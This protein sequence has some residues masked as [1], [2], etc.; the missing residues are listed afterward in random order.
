MATHPSLHPRAVGVQRLRRRV[1]GT[2]AVLTLAVLATACGSSPAPGDPGPR[3]TRAGDCNDMPHLHADPGFVLGFD[4]HRGEHRYDETVVVYA[5]ASDS[6]PSTLTLEPLPHG[7]TA[8]PSVVRLEGTGNGLIPI[9]LTVARGA[10]GVLS[11][12]QRFDGGSGGSA[13]GPRVVGGDDG[14]RL[15]RR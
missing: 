13:G 6:S 7:V 11:V 10:S 8:S 9:R 3:P 4:W 5:C 15:E 12:T 2:A 14:W 1:P